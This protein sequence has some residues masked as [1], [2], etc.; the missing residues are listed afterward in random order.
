MFTL[1]YFY[2]G[3][4]DHPF[5]FGGLRV[6]FLRSSYTLEIRARREEGGAGYY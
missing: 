4:V 3:K 6:R 5:L 2:F 1:F